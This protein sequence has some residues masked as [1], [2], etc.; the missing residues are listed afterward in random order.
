MGG[1]KKHSLT[2]TNAA[3]SS[4][5]QKLLPHERLGEEYVSN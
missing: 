5:R 4:G 2:G 1:K 3:K